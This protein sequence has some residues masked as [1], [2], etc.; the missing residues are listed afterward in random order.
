MGAKKSTRK[1]ATSEK[2]CSFAYQKYFI[3]SLLSP[4]SLPSLPSSSARMECLK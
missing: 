1:F 3:F 4:S 2:K